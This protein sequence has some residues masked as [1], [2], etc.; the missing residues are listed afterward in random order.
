MTPPVAH[1]WAFAPRFRRRAFGWRSQPAAQRVREAT[2]EIEKVT[3]RIH[4]ISR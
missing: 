3:P 2:A 1:K 4:P